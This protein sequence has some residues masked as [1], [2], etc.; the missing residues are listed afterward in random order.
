MNKSLLTRTE[1]DALRGLAILGIFLHNYC[2]WLKVMVKENE[3]Q[4]FQS[5]AQHF[6]DMLLHPDA[7]L[8]LQ[9][10]SFLGHYGVPIF[11]FISA[12]GLVMKYEQATTAAVH[13]E[14]IWHFFTTHYKKLFKMM[15]VGFVAFTLVD[16]ITPH[17]HHYQVVDILAMMGM[18]NNLLP[19]P[20]TII[21]PGPYWFFGLMLQF[22]LVFRIFLFKKSWKIIVTF[23]LVCLLIQLC[24]SPEGETLNRYR[25]NFMG[26]MLPFGLGM[27]YAR[28]GK[29]L[30]TKCHLAIA[31]ISYPLILILSF[32]FIGW[33]FLPIFICTAAISTIKLVGLFPHSKLYHCISWIGSI[34]SALF[35]CHPITRKI[36]IPL[37]HQGD[38]YTGLLLYI[39]TSI[40][41]AWSFRELIKHIPIK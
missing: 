11:L 40:C 17:S 9:L 15:I 16:L 39:I 4:F 19:H 28:Y 23:I 5:N 26:G 12:Y 14:S 25:Y 27:L 24:L 37:S 6:G 22:Y 31:F 41:L 36:F 3:Y 38:I 7:L 30:S 21:W 10:F 2:H 34:S 18:F 29:P 35:I 20:N 13:Q 32:N 33:T 8:P 1:C